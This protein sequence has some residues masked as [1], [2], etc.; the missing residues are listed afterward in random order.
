MLIILCLLFADFAVKSAK[1]KQA[2]GG[3]AK[4]AECR[5]GFRRFFCYVTCFFTLLIS[6]EFRKQ[7]RT[8]AR[9]FF[10]AFGLLLVMT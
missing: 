9:P 3:D 5:K 6:V 4:R 2:G 7:K 8:L 10:E 1:S